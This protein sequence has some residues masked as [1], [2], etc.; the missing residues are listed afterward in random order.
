ME[1]SDERVVSPHFSGHAHL[2][3]CGVSQRPRQPWTA[4]STRTRL[5]TSSVAL[6]R[7]IKRERSCSVNGAK[8]EWT[9][10]EGPADTG[11]G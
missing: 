8:S 3:F 4:L 11:P 6:V 7:R 2:W 5:L 10:L 1:E 9:R